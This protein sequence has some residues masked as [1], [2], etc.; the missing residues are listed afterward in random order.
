M[1]INKHTH[2]RSGF[3][4]I[5]LLTVIAIIGILAGI[6]IPTVGAVRKRAAMI[7]SVNN[8]KQIGIAYS[9]FSNTGKRA[10]VI[11]K[12]SWSTSSS[13]SANNMKD[14]AKVLAYHAQL[15]DASIWFIGSDEN[16]SG[17]SGTLPRSIGSKDGSEF[18]ESSEWKSMPEDVISYSAV[19]DMNAISPA[20]T[21]LAW[22]KGLQ[23]N[24]EWTPTSPWL[25]EGGH[26]VFMDGH[27]EFFE[28]LT[29]D[30]NKLTPGAASSTNAST[31]NISVAIKTT[32]KTSYLLND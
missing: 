20:A 25:G 14:W 32:S 27:V 1:I 3:T 26:I 31:S 9:T 7:T 22:T 6:L 5:E 2:T 23:T 19:V 4:L 17:Y 16:V 8:L 18:Q 11:S 29:D 24:G 30:E 12:G 13:R 28:N 15:T 21:P 10:R